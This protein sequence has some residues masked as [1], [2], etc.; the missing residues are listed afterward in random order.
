MLLYA[1]GTMLF[2]LAMTSALIVIASDF[3]HYR[4]AMMAALRS[5]SLDGL[6]SPAP[7]QAMPARTGQARR[8]TP[9]P[10]WAMQP[11]RSA[12]GRGHS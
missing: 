12:A 8:I 2:A 5:L 9:A 10:A 11:R 4:R 3:M 7:T 1:F 6:P